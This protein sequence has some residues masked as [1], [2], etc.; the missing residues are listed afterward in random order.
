MSMVPSEI[1]CNETARG[2]VG[3]GHEPRT[4]PARRPRA[5]GHRGG[6]SSHAAPVSATAKR[7]RHSP[8]LGD[9]RRSGALIIDR[10]ANE[11]GSS[12]GRTAILACAR[13]S[14]SPR[15]GAFA[16]ADVFLS[17]AGS[18]ASP[19]TWRASLTGASASRAGSSV[20]RTG[21]F[22]ALAERSASLVTGSLA[23]RDSRASPRDSRA[24]PRAASFGGAG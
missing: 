13:S 24:S 7:T 18:S 16:F 15:G 2:N 10:P 12:C 1:G 4:E 8:A 22:L 9:M 20:Q 17:P 14:A 6:W 11:Q 19:M 23:P 5:D 3:G 21:E